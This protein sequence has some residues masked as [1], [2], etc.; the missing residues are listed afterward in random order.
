M[1]YDE[2]LKNRKEEDLLEIIYYE[3]DELIR[4]QDRGNYASTMVQEI[5]ETSPWE[6]DPS[7]TAYRVSNENAVGDRYMIYQCGMFRQFRSEYSGLNLKVGK[8]V[9]WIFGYRYFDRLGTLGLP[10]IQ[11]WGEGTIKLTETTVVDEGAVANQMTSIML[12]A[13]SVSTMLAAVF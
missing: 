1:I 11:D 9:E 13:L 5:V 12:L 10:T 3:G 2:E 6:N 8:E 7:L 4:K